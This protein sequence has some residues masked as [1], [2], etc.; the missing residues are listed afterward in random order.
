MGLAFQLVAAG[1]AKEPGIPNCCMVDIPLSDMA[2]ILYMRV[3]LVLVAML[4]QHQ[5]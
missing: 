3:I 4:L 5:P 1:V 2:G